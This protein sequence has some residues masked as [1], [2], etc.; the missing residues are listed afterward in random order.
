MR[1]RSRG[2]SGLPKADLHVLLGLVANHAPKQLERASIKQL[3]GLLKAYAA[4]D[5][6]LH[7]LRFSQVKAEDKPRLAE[8]LV[9]S[10]KA[11]VASG[12]RRYDAAA[13]A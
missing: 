11:A 13:F 4:A 9:A 1:R 12:F 5:A 8:A 10:I 7:G 2:S 6:E 3:K